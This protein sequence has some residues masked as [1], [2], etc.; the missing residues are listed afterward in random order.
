MP[1]RQGDEHADA[2][3][4]KSPLDAPPLCRG[5]RMRADAILAFR[6]I[7]PL[8]VLSYPASHDATNSEASHVSRVGLTLISMSTCKSRMMP[9][10]CAF[11]RSVKS[12]FHDGQIR[13]GQRRAAAARAT[14]RHL[15]D[16][17]GPRA[18][19]DYIA[20]SCLYRFAAAGRAS[21]CAGRRRQRRH[22]IARP[23]IPLLCIFTLRAKVLYE[24]HDDGF[25]SA[26]PLLVLTV[27]AIT[28]LSLLNKNT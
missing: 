17:C 6:Y 21:A 20:W 13:A 26:R 4:T 28:F 27:S 10:S 19:R 8:R 15:H 16:G 1:W 12:S 14:A 24:S 11:R 5:E 7:T 18:A 25:A 23:P 9:F 3:A 22:D 2:T